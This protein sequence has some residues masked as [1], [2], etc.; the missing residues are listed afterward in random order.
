MTTSSASNSTSN[1]TPT[2]TRFTAITRGLCMTTLAAAMALSGCANMDQTQ[3]DSSKGALLGALGG[4]VLG[5]ATGGSRGATTGAV[6]GGAAGAAGG[7]IWSRKMQEQKAA[8]E[9]A[10][11]GTG[12]TVSQTAD[13]QL[14]LDVPSDVSFDIGRANIKPDFG[15]V[16]SQFAT[17]LN[18]NPATSVSIVGH[19]D[20]TGSDAS[21]Q[22][23]SVER[24]ISAR[25][26][27]VARGVAMNRI[28]TDGRGEREPI[29]D[30]RT[31]EGRAQNRR[32]EIHVAE[33]MM[34]PAR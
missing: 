21:N 13:N 20:N 8:M 29:A 14:K 6:L 34:A 11:A 30:N 3:R 23:L 10:T 15:R 28:S 7:Y 17:T 32:V 1:T 2:T 24:A 4:A 22:T 12:V 31:A 9:A 33:P 26:Y 19:T 27:L 16:L 18:A 5:A 25:N